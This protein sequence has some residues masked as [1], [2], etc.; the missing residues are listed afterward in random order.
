VRYLAT[1]TVDHLP[2]EAGGGTDHQGARG[3]VERGDGA[4][5]GGAMRDCT[6]ERVLVLTGISV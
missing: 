1:T 6:E 4:E 3:K 2:L 5:P